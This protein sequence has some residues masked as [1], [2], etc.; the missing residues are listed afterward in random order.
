MRKPSFTGRVVVPPS[1][2]HIR[3][4]YKVEAGLCMDKYRS[5]A[6]PVAR[7]QRDVDASDYT[8]VDG[9]LRWRL[10]V[11]PQLDDYDGS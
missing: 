5:L 11:W 7:S 4:Q 1:R 10:L 3:S 9:T 2:T 8:F 6:D